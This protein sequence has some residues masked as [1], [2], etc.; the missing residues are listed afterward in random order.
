M[1]RAELLEALGL[2]RAEPG[3]F[4]EALL[5]DRSG[6]V[7][8][9]VDRQLG[10]LGTAL[11]G[12]I[13]LLNPQVVALGG[14]LAALH[15]YDPERLMR[16]VAASTLAPSL[17]G[18]R[19]TAAELGRGPAHGGCCR[20]RRPAVAGRPCLDQSLTPSH[21]ELPWSGPAQDQCGRTS[22]SGTVS[23]VSGCAAMRAVAQAK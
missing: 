11:A 1:T 7:A 8:A 2:T 21:A 23:G 3:Q 4:E 17:E 16:A 10:H 14:F 18:V 19:I 9:V 22:P 5:A 13:N 15:A 20:P 6:R 12:A